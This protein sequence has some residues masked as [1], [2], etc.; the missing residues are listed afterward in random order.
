MAEA[1]AD[2]G[3]VAAPLVA[4]MLVE[5]RGDPAGY[6]ARERRTR[7]AVSEADRAEAVSIAGSGTSRH[8]RAIAA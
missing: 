3:V 1:G 5:R 4:G 6:G 2:R 8:G 7:V